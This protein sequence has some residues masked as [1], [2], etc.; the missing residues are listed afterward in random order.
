[1]QRI[2]HGA[3]NELIRQGIRTCIRI[4]WLHWPSWLLYHSS[5]TH[6][7]MVTMD[8]QISESCV[9]A[10]HE[11]SKFCNAYRCVASL[12]LMPRACLI[13]LAGRKQVIPTHK[14]A[15][16]TCNLRTATKWCQRVGTP[17]LAV[18]WT[19]VDLRNGLTHSSEISTPL[20]IK[21]LLLEYPTRRLD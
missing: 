9:S 18:N 11:L 17:G 14:S 19:H 3:K 8:E 21:V 10:F 16:T 12:R 1:M 20:S 15:K 6:R 13:V 5:H 2:L 4:L 7:S